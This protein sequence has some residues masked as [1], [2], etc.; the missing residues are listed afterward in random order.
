M[1]GVK[2]KRLRKQA[3]GLSVGMPR[4]RLIAKKHN[5]I[6]VI[7]GKPETYA[8]LQIFNDPKTMRGIYLDLKKGRSA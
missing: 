1:R 4:R 6:V 5:K 2:A 3:R 7:E 8:A